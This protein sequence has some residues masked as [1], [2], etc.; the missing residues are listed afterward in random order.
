MEKIS[1]FLWQY[2]IQCTVHCTRYELHVLPFIIPSKIFVL[3]LYFQFSRG[4]HFCGVFFWNSEPALPPSIQ[5]LPIYITE[6]TVVWQIIL[7]SA[8]KVF[9]LSLYFQLSRDRCFCGIFFW[10]SEPAFISF[11]LIVA[12]L[13]HATTNADA[14]LGPREP[15]HALPRCDYAKSLQTSFHDWWPPP[16]RYWRTKRYRSI[17][18]AAKLLT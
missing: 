17:R 13:L 4:R 1:T 9:V 16:P 7:I 5:L 11:N 18:F 15:R 8:S 12:N 3:S 2:K 6:I 10:D 14:H